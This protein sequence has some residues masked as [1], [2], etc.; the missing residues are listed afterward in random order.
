MAPVLLASIDSTN[1]VHLIV[2]WNALANSRCSKSFE[3]G[4]VPKILAPETASLNYGIVKKID[5]GQVEWVK[6]SFEEAYLTN[7]GRPE[8]DGVV[9]AVFVTTL[10]QHSLSNLACFGNLDYH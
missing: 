1:H 9:D 7:L 2:G 5:A 8:V 6:G 10:T 3:L 4:A